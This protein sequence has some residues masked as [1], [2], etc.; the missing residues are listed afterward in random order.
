MRGYTVLRGTHRVQAVLGLSVTS[1]GIGLGQRLL[2]VE[3]GSWG[4]N[5]A[6]LVAQTVKNLPGMQETWVRSLGQEDT[7]EKG[8]TTH[9]SILA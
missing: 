3:A 4:M 6:S 1:L 9:S 2:H 8:K 5:E 7:L